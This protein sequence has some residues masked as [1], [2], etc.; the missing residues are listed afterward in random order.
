[1][2]CPICFEPS[3]FHAGRCH[4]YAPT[5]G[6]S[7]PGNSKNFMVWLRAKIKADALAAAEKAA[8][9]KVAAITA[10]TASITD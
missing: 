10:S 3:G 7:G 8:A 9:Q 2:N 5:E 1:M 6:T 4:E